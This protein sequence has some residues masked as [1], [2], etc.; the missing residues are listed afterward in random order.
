MKAM[1]YED[2]RRRFP[3]D[4]APFVIYDR[5][6]SDLQDTS[7]GINRQRTDVTPPFRPAPTGFYRG[8]ACLA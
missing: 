1:T 5:Y 2:W 3:N 6:S 8:L 7:T 4:P